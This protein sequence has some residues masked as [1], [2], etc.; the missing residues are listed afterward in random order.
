MQ[1]SALSTRLAGSSILGR[2]G[3]ERDF[4][5]SKSMKVGV[6]GLGSM[7]YGMATS[8]VRAGHETYGFD[9]VEAQVA[10]FCKDGGKTGDLATVAPVLD[11]IVVVVLNAAQTEDALFGDHAIMPHVRRGACVIA[12]ATTPPEFARAMARRCSE[13]WVHYLD[14]PISGGAAAAAAGELSIMASGPAAAF[15]AARPALGAMATK[16]FELGDEVGAGSAMKSVNQLLAGVHIATMAEAM[17]F[18]MTQG[19]TP[20]RFLEV[21]PQCAGASWMLENR[22]PHVANGDYTP[23]S[24]V[25]IWLKDLGIVLDIAREAKFSAPMTASALQQFMAASGSGLGREDD[26]AVAKVYARNAGLSLPGDD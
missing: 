5:M 15:S 12:C 3:Q 17:T 14:A 25:D 24:A 18:A 7:G 9:R 21:I 23:R 20:E 10:R 4:E 13:Y 11:I 22:G 1:A 8:L 16:V 6:I 19:I 26:A 2:T